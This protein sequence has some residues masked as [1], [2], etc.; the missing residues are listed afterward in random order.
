MRIQV[1]GCTHR[2]A[3]IATRERLSF[4]PA[5]TC[6]ALEQLR[7][8]FPGV[9]AVLLST[10]NRVEL[11]TACENGCVPTLEELVEF[12]AGFHG[13]NP[14]DI[15][16]CLCAQEGAEAVRHLFTVASSLDSMVGGEPQILAQV[17]QAY[18]LADEQR[19]TG[20]LMHAAFQAAL[21]TA[22]RVSVETAIHQ[23]RVSIPSLAVADFAQQ[24]FERFDDKKALVIGAGKMAAET[25]KY[26][27]DQGVR[28]MLVV[29]RSLPRAIEL[30]RQWQ[31]KVAA[32]DQLLDSIA[33]VDLVITATGAKE[34][35]LTVE[36]FRTIESRRGGRPLFILDLAVPRDFDAKIGQRPGVYLY[37]VDDLREAC[38][39]NRRQ[40]QRELPQALEIIG[41]E[42]A[43]FFRA[44]QHRAVGP[45][46]QRVRESWQNVQ[47][48]EMERL[49]RKLPH[50]DQR[51]RREIGCS[52]SRLVNKLLHPPLESLREESQTTAAASMLD[53]FSRLFQLTD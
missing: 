18:Q 42:T 47:D 1:L 40:R 13:L 52:F 45:V 9:E 23:R 41:H 30:A 48:R 11:Y 46:V 6:A 50:L 38:E 24:I 31:G 43:H 32:W 3:A 34:S 44:I 19:S 15:G 33:A 51:A 21:K 25:L 37:S 7:S 26:L 29:N 49:L 5:Q 28:D 36:Q 2:S 27:R 22:R 20:P 14:A 35:I 16:D 17:K 4:S 53:A 8:R 39:E 12:L 10:C